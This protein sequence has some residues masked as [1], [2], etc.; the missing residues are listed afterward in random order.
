[1]TAF[2]E[3]F[4]RF[5]PDMLKGAGVT[6]LLTAE[7]L[8]AGFVLG[9]LASLARTYGNKFW[10]GVA[11][12]YIELFRGTPLL[13]QL[14]LIYY[15]LPG[16]GVTFSREL[17]AF[18][19]L[20]LNSGAYQAEYLRGSI[21]AIGDGQMMAGRS[22][23][24]SRIK[25]IWHIILPQALRLAI[26]AWSNEPVSLLKSTAVVFLI[27]VPELMAKAKSIAAQTY[28][29]IGTYLAVALVYLAM[30][31]LLDAVLRWIERATRIPGFEMEGRK[32]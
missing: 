7:G 11:V 25:T 23:G 30:V 22:I 14:F 5:L 16:L 18:L 17:S 3:F 32:A 28:D 29:P 8:A 13:M 10:R 15:G 20:G 9:L 6:V 27:A 24:M 26:P 1:M 19:A 4:V 12:S 21:L 2:F 31:Y